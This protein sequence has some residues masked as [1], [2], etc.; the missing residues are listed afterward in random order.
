M[1]SDKQ[2][3][4]NDNSFLNERKNARYIN[5][6]DKTKRNLLFLATLISLI[7]IGTIYLLLDI[8]NIYRIS[9]V[10]NIY[11]KDEDIVELSGLTTSNKFLFVNSS[12]IENKI[13]TN[14]MVDTCKVEKIENRL[15]RITVQEKKAIGYSYEDSQNV[16]IL[17][18]DSRVNIDKNNLYLIEKVPLIEGFD[19]DKLVLLEKNLV[20]VDYKMI[21]EISE[22]HYFPSL[23]FQ[24]YEIIMRDG[25][26]IFTS[27]YGMSLINRYYDVANS[28]EGR[29]NNCYYI[30]D[31]SGNV[32]M[33]ACPWEKVEE[34]SSTT[35]KEDNQ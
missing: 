3:I 19:K 8:S 21:N 11:L 24:D 5:K 31:I 27:V 16:L 30:E 34:S 13:K 32:Y 10:G 12:S 14:K 29:E 4:L 28:Y 26:Y 1:L 7:I 17:S 9:V 15:I 22:L 25:N 35:E 6:Y 18:D 2:K 20:D 33:S 23:K